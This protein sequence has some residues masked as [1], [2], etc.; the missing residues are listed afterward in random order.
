MAKM[1]NDISFPKQ[2][3]SLTFYISSHKDSV[4]ELVMAP[5]NC[6]QIIVFAGS[7]PVEVKFKIFLFIILIS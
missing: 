3:Y 4:A 5:H 2:V 6:L 1:L 7:I